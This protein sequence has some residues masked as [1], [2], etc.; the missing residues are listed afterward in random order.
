MS[1]RPELV[2]FDLGG[3]LIELRGVATMARLSGID[4]EQE[5]WRRWLECRWVRTFESGLCTPEE[6]SRG[7][8]EDWA[9]S[10]EPT[11]FLEVFASWPAGPMLGAEELVRDLADQVI[12]GCLS[13][14]NTLHWDGQVERWPLIGLFDRCFVSHR[15]GLVKP[16]PE[17]FVRVA[18][19][20]SVRVSQV[21]LLDDNLVNVE[22]ARSVGFRAEHV[23][24]VDEARGALADHGLKPSA[25]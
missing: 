4:D 17:I 14:T 9:L 13:N 12:L 24:G 7:V 16:D 18:E 10:I 19:Q 25:G 11:E 1:G 22:A 8:V 2:L 6:F 21:L 3:V 23:I 15:L 5:L 20:L